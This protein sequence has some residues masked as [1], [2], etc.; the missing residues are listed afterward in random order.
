[1]K[2]LILIALIILIAGCTSSSFEYQEEDTKIKVLERPSDLEG[3]VEVPSQEPVDAWA[4]IIWPTVIWATIFA[5]GFLLITMIK[6]GRRYH[7]W[8]I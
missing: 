3:P 8:E 6:G 1:M 7:T 4:D 5:I 2:Y